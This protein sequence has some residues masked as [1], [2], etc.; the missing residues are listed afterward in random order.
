[1][2]GAEMGGGQKSHFANSPDEASNASIISALVLGESKEL[3][4]NEAPHAVANENLIA[5]E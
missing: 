4:D 5:G 3:L 2:G 1:M